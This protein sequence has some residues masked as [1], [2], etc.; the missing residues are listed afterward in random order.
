MVD[1]VDFRHKRLRVHHNLFLKT[2]DNWKRKNYTKTND[3][4]RIISL[5]DDTCEIIGIWKKRQEEMNIHD[6]M[7]SSSTF[8]G[9]N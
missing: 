8:G 6:F 4:K 5:D 7:F 1:D 2:K 3:R 9:D